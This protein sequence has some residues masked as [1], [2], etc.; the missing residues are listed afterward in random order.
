MA[1]Y[2]PAKCQHCEAGITLVKLANEPGHI[3]SYAI[4]ECL[5]CQERPEYILWS[6][7]DECNKAAGLRFGAV[8]PAAFQ[9]C[10]EPRGQ[11]EM[12]QA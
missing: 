7:I 8:S 11:A 3:M 2:I 10:P 5:N 1:T 12:G 9:P 4:S 6:N